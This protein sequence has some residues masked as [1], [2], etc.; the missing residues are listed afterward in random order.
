MSLTTMNIHRVNCIDFGDVTEV[1]S[2]DGHEYR[3]ARYMRRIEFDAEDGSEHTFTAFF[4]DA[5][6]E[7]IDRERDSVNNTVAGQL[8]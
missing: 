1:R 2:S 6:N 5:V 3:P 8:R 4:C 7:R